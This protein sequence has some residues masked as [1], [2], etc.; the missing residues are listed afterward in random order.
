MI[1]EEL[2]Q[3][4]IAE[5]SDL[6]DDIEPSLVEYPRIDDV[7]ERTEI[8]NRVFR[9]FHS[10]K[11]SAGFVGLHDIARLTHEAET[12]LEQYRKVPDRII[13]GNDIA[14]LCRTVDLLR[15]IFSAGG[16]SVDQDGN[17]LGID[18]LIGEIV[19]AT[20][21][22]KSHGSR[23]TGVMTI[24]LSDAPDAGKTDDV[25][26]DATQV[27]DMATVDRLTESIEQS[28]KAEAEKP[29]KDKS[30]TVSDKVP[31]GKSKTS[32]SQKDTR[33]RR[34][35][36]DTARVIKTRDLA[37]RETTANTN[38][39]AAK[40]VIEANELLEQIEQSLLQAEQHPDSGND[41]IQ[42]ALRC[43]HSF[44]GNSGFMNLVDL[45]RLSHRM[46]SEVENNIGRSL[47]L[48]SQTF[49]ALLQM[50]DV[51]RQGVLDF[52]C[53]GSGAIPE[54]DA[55][56]AMLDEFGT[57]RDTEVKRHSTQV[58]RLGETKSATPPPPPVTEKEEG[59]KPAET[60]TRRLPTPKLDDPRRRVTDTT[61]LMLRGKT[62]TQENLAEMP[63][64]DNIVIST[65]MPEPPPAAP[66]AP[67]AAGGTSTA[68]QPRP[69]DTT[70]RF[71][72]TRA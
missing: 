67:A 34:R 57:A 13:P 9:H 64:S 5:A 15:A 2:L 52:S 66:A 46:E 14:L 58:L 59:K 23:P 12:L 70:K 29:G 62:S 56:I 68:A 8:V 28:D 42:E 4:F 38:E 45:E 31:S 49:D 10:I 27:V 72:D 19:L 26:P 32:V 65:E 3:S 37:R 11:G 18:A 22:M 24:N 71:R 41:A 69:S 35:S 48:D 39:F 50:I 54:A 16:E 55:Y 47:G 36:S 44:K 17:E 6:L 60:P 43:L 20:K 40:Y 21:Q 30:Q 25:G 63:K 53:G 1:S 51:L 33:S 61:R 7:D